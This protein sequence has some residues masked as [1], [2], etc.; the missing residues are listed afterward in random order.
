MT[1]LA[2]SGR[3]KRLMSMPKPMM[4]AMI[5]SASLCLALTLLT[6]GTNDV[7]FFQAY[8]VK[9]AHDGTAA[10]YRDGASPRAFHTK[11]VESAAALPPAMLTFCTAI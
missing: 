7:L 1:N 6:Y 11:W 4:A 3:G 9:A 10:L 2:E 5:I 8:A